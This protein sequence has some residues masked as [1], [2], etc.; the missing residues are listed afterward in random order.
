MGKKSFLFLFIVLFA[1]VSACKTKSYRP[2]PVKK[3]KCD[4][5]HFSQNALSSQ[6]VYSIALCADEQ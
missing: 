2:K 4:C 1:C 5:P 6:S 3:K